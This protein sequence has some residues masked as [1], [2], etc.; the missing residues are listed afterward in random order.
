MAACIQNRLSANGE[1][2]LTQSRLKFPFLADY[3]HTKG[4]GQGR[5]TF[6]AT[7]AKAWASEVA[8]R[9]CCSRLSKHIAG[10]AIMGLTRLHYEHANTN[11]RQEANGLTSCESRERST[12][13]PCH[14]HR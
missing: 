14:S 8:P 13:Y 2:I 7:P 11:E 10:T 12:P 6:F 9:S 3:D 1:E 5:S 4:N